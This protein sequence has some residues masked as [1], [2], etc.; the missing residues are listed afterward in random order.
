MSTKEIIAQKIVPGGDCIGNI[1]GKTVFIP[2]AIPGEKLEIE[3]TD[4]KRDYDTGKILKIIEKMR[5]GA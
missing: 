4:S 1:G 3:I 2:F 5:H